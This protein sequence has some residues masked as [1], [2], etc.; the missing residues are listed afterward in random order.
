VFSSDCEPLLFAIF[1]INTVLA[2]YE[3]FQ[4]ILTK[5]SYVSDPWNY[6]DFIRM[7][8]CFVYIAMHWAGFNKIYAEKVLVGL[9]FVTMVRGISY[10][11]LFD[12]TR[13][14]IN[15]LRE[16][17]KDMKSFLILL[18]YSTYSFALIYFIMVNNVLKYSAEATANPSSVEIK[19]FSEYIALS[20]LLSLGSF[21]TSGYGAFEWVIFFF[22][23]VI[24]P[25][26]MLN[27]LIAIMGDTY[28][29]VAEEQEIADMQELTEMVIEGEYLLFC[30]RN[31]GVRSYMQICKEEELSAQ[32]V[33]IEQKLDKLKVRVKEVE[34]SFIQRSQE[35][36]MEVQDTIAGINSKVDEMTGLIEQ[37]SL[38]QD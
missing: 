32:D 13:Y 10:F 12:N 15:L 4:M 28:S 16:T 17:I 3:V 23:S 9:I 18:T 24:N 36:R 6:I 35:M 27:L 2:C 21:D 7:S 11:R 19:P 20:Y 25:L 22:A 29:R 14:M 1:L 33:T 37:I 26:I 34:T 5:S 31:K 30:K 8:L 38:T